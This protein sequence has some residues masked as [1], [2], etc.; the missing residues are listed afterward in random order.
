MKPERKENPIENGTETTPSLHFLR[1]ILPSVVDEDSSRYDEMIRPT[2]SSFTPYYFLSRIL[3]ACV[4]AAS[5]RNT[6]LFLD[7]PIFLPPCLIFSRSTALFSQTGKVFPVRSLRYR[8]CDPFTLHKGE[9]EN[10]TSTG[11]REREREIC[12]LFFH[13]TIKEL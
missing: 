7:R 10:G 5:T 9:K 8:T 12:P 11:R 3:S 1:I 6:A 4:R 2:R 13:G